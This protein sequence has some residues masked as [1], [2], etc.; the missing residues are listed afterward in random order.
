LDLLIISA[1]SVNGT[2]AS[3]VDISV[4]VNDVP[5]ALNFSG[6]ELPPAPRPLKVEVTLTPQASHLFPVTGSFVYLGEGRL[7]P[8]DGGGPPNFR[9][10]RAVSIE[11]GSVVMS[12]IGYVSRLR[13]V[14]ARVVESLSSAPDRRTDEPLL[15]T[16]G[17]LP[18]VNYVRTLSDP[19]VQGGQL[20]F[21]A[22]TEIDPNAELLI[23]ELA[24]D[25]A[26]KLLAVTC[27]RSLIS[28]PQRTAITPP[29][30]LLYFHSTA[31]QNFPDFYSGAYPF[32]FDFVH[33]GLLK[34]VF[35]LPDVEPLARW[36]GKG[37]PYQM[38]AAGAQAIYVL[39]L[40]KPFDEV[41]VMIDATS[42]Q[43]VLEEIVA[44]LFHGAGM[45]V[46]PGLGR[47]A[48]AG[49][50]SGNLLVTRFL[51]KNAGTPFLDNVLKEVYNFDIPS[52]QMPK[53]EQVA[54]A[55]LSSGDSASK[56]LRMYTQQDHP[57]EFG[58]LLGV[59]TPPGPYVINDASGQRTA[60]FLSTAAWLQVAP[61]QMQSA[62]DFQTV[63]Q[64]IAETC[65]LDAARRSGFPKLP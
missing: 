3:G 47:V 36:G 17:A 55:W 48:L 4:K 31:G 46:E 28:T 8:L 26:P 1:A 57:A 25:P 38:H 39:P 13:D 53:F 37:M 63:H 29:S 43:A 18:P 20:V 23:L 11:D 24:A 34:Y 35:H 10:V 50:S 5:A 62:S 12:L 44:H 61:G 2:T 33:F 49:F 30:V 51:E 42:A 19:P 59:S 58:K 41:G 22:A 64:L 14:T 45:F 16:T 54:S 9:P 65:L 15:T 21:D 32:S 7:L 6:V 56:M 40:N 27:P 52:S 60:A